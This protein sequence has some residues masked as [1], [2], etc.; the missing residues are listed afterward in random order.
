MTYRLI[1]HEDD[2]DYDTETYREPNKD[3]LI[4]LLVFILRTDAGFNV[5]VIYPGGD[6]WV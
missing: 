2:S 3:E 4:S 6:E 5:R 1:L